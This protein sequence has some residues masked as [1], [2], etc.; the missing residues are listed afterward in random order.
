MQLCWIP[1]RCLAVDL[2]IHRG[3]S[4]GVIHDSLIDEDFN[5]IWFVNF[6]CPWTAFAAIFFNTRPWN[7]GGGSRRP[8]NN[9]NLSVPLELTRSS[10]KAR[11]KVCRS[12]WAAEAWFNVYH[13]F[14]LHIQPV[15]SCFTFFHRQIKRLHV[16][17][18]GVLESFHDSK[19]NQLFRSQLPALTLSFCLT[20]FLWIFLL[21]TIK[22]SIYYS[23]Q[24]CW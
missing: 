15:F 20:L 14:H 13:I 3:E 9:G 18:G 6:N 11:L 24:M 7:W 16:K 22:A 12:P 17:K 10:S 8:L 21:N 4:Q 5:L 1:S 2:S 23:F 19:Q